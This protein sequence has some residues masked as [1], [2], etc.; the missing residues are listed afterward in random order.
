M[1][2]APP[3]IN[4][5]PNDDPVEEASAQVNRDPRNS[6]QTGNEIS[7]PP[8]LTDQLVKS[9]K[10]F[11]SVPLLTL[12]G[13]S[14]A[15]F[16]KVTLKL[17]K[18]IAFETHGSSNEIRTVVLH[19]IPGLLHFFIEN[20]INQQGRSLK[21]LTQSWHTHH[22][23]AGII[24]AYG[25]EL[26][27]AFYDLDSV[28]Q[29]ASTEVAR[30]N[31]RNRTNGTLTEVKLRKKAILA[32]NKKY[33]LEGLGDAMKIIR[34]LK[35]QTLA[36]DPIP[37]A[38]QI[39]KVAALHP[40][41]APLLLNNPQVQG[42]VEEL[43][44]DAFT[45]NCVLKDLPKASAVGSDSWSFNLL[46]KLF[47]DEHLKP[48]SIPRAT[49][50]LAIFTS[51]LNKL[52]SGDLERTHWTD[53]RICLIP[54]GPPGE[55]RPISI[56]SAIYRILSRCVKCLTINTVQE[57][58]GITQLGCGYKSA[59][60][61]A[62]AIFQAYSEETDGSI[63]I[64]T[65]FKN[66]FNTI[67]RES[68]LQGIENSCPALKSFFLWAYGNSTTLFN[69][70]HE[71]V[72]TSHTGCRQGDPMSPILF[73][74]GIHS[75]LT[76]IHEY[77]RTLDPDS[78]TLGYMDDITIG[79]RSNLIEQVFPFIVDLF[80]DDSLQLNPGK[81]TVAGPFYH[82]GYGSI[83]NTPHFDPGD[84]KHSPLGITI[85]GV[86]VGS[87]HFIN[88]QISSIVDDSVA[89][90]ELISKLCGHHIS[91]PRDFP[92]LEAQLAFN[93][94]RFCIIPQLNFIFRASKRELGQAHAERFDSA[95][96]NF[97]LRL[98]GSNSVPPS[99][100]TRLLLFLPPRWGGTG[101]C[102]HSG[103]YGQTQNLLGIATYADFIQ[104]HQT[105]FTPAFYDFFLTHIRNRKVRIGVVGVASD[106]LGFISR[107]F[108]NRRLDDN[109]PFQH[110]N[111]QVNLR[112]LCPLL[113]EVTYNFVLNYTLQTIKDHHRT[114][115]IRSVAFVGSGSWISPPK[116]IRNSKDLSLTSFEFCRL[117]RNQ[118]LITPIRGDPLEQSTCRCG[119]TY[120][121]ND[122]RA[123]THPTC[124]P[125]NKSIFIPRHD[126]IQAAVTKEILR[127]D[128]LAV[129]NYK[130]SYFAPG[131]TE[132]READFSIS[133][134]G[135]LHTIID[136][137]VVC[138]T[139]PLQDTR[140]IYHPDRNTNDACRYAE[141][142]KITKYN[143]HLTQDQRDRFVPFAIESTGRL[144]PRA[145]A[146]LDRIFPPVDNKCTYKS[147]IKKITQIITKYTAKCIGY[148]NDHLAPT[149]QHN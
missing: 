7:W 142:K 122:H 108:H 16:I 136:F 39:E 105:H 60:E 64:K 46:N 139:A 18:D 61:T 137:V 120:Y 130:P 147:L 38:E 41:S 102:S 19:F 5:E 62:A 26:M 131:Q 148:F 72:G 84:L 97:N 133:R 113:D 115:W 36:S 34:Y 53:S 28:E 58:L 65:D 31:L 109:T 10:T 51:L 4:E 127:R 149:R 52:L 99:I 85:L 55:Y 11:F 86:P 141:A 70:L 40:Y 20:N 14:R 126:E 73:C 3:P 94:I 92:K 95:V 66:A 1:S 81:C 144:G 140:S 77:V 75:K 128:D 57:S 125:S 80:R 107:Y 59:C 89:Y 8:D 78:H 32:A 135:N 112:G 143:T 47:Y 23:P 76:L 83:I 96:Y 21:A 12:P 69:S 50:P 15:N 43:V 44:I 138:P 123:L 88:S 71:I 91:L 33:K 124:C 17:M 134:Q 145:I 87:D 6:A 25:L 63:I 67:S 68:I 54:K 111:Q 13:D 119:K 2:A 93:L 106:E 30:W 121:A 101:L 118:L 22:D 56:N 82:S 42:E 45:L 74:L 132:R 49:D 27:R 35:N 24:F 90:I 110:G 48:D 146:F 98:I 103:F 114:A 116:F 37:L 104:N 117:L 79:C 9:F 129:I 100:T 29:L